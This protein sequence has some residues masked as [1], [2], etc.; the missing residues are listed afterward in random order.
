MNK[1]KIIIAGGGFAGLYA[2]R[3]FDKHLARQPDVQ[4][5]LISR[6][7]FILFTP[8]LH[9]VAAG[10]LSPNDIVNP[11]RRI[12]RHVNVVEADVDRIDLSTQ[13]IHCSAGVR[14]SNIEFKFDHLLLTIGS[15]T[16]FFDMP[17]VRD[18]AVTMKSL[19][20][21]T[22][23]RN[24]VI[25]LLEEA[26]LE[27]HESMRKELLTFVI[28]GGGFA[29]V[30]TTGA[31]NDFVR[32]TVKYY[33]SLRD[34]AIRVAV[35]HPGKFLLPE[36]GEELGQYTEQKL[37]ARKVEIIKGA[38]VASY[39]GSTVELSNGTR[40][41]ATTLVWTAGVKPSPVI[42][43]LDCRKERGRV[44]VNE[45]LAVPGV[46]GLWAAGDCAAVP[47]GK[48]GEFYPPT[49]QH[50][51]R[52]AIVA[53]KNIEATIVGRALKPFA[54]KTLGQLATIGRHTGVAM[55]FGFKFS[56][57]V[58]WAMWRTVYLLKLPRLSKKLRVMMGWT[59]DLVF[60]REI[61]QLITVRDVQGLMDRLAR[62][63]ARTNARSFEQ[64]S[65]GAPVLS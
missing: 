8:M 12:L 31:I 13:A 65:E 1:T 9:E 25:A 49:A 19:A 11:L 58:A 53:A 44:L 5:T 50:G 57:F 28:A 41:R 55:M 15:E 42:E 56:G 32:E 39:D 62:I 3:Y 22:L 36:L 27:Q 30:E 14:D 46:N 54:F 23:L 51:L 43:S 45:Y 52:E 61:E 29:G 6:E 47:A 34:E 4:V 38:R 33:P 59:L 24:R 48:A 21:A 63:R 7:N 16:N 26:S 37:S 18:W 40:I 60:G 17:G 2:A 20:D 35:I 64:T 10:D